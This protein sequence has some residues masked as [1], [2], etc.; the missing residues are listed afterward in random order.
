EPFHLFRVRYNFV[1]HFHG[2]PLK[3]IQPI[4]LL[5]QVMYIIIFRWR[6]FFHRVNTVVYKPQGRAEEE[7]KSSA[8]AR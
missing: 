2:D 6:V 8:L 7:I 5:D 1:Y 4:R 3:L